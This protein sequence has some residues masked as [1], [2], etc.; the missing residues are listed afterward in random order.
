MHLVT[1]ASSVGQRVGTLTGGPH[2]SHGAAGSAF[3]PAEP[4]RALQPLPVS[5]RSRCLYGHLLPVSSRSRED[6]TGGASPSPVRFTGDQSG[7]IAVTQP[8]VIH[9]QFFLQNSALH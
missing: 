8:S 6:P 5:S 1:L 7:L 3:G 9:T 2:W 4:R